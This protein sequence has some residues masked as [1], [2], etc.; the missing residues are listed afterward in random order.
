MCVCVCGGG[1]GGG[2]PVKFLDLSVASF[3]HF[4]RLE[5]GVPTGFDIEFWF[6]VFKSIICNSPLP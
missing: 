4:C 6:V 1:G 2:S 5:F 3:A